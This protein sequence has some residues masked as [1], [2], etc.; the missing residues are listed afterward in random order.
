[1]KTRT[2]DLSILACLFC[3]NGY[4]QYQPA[5]RVVP[6]TKDTTISPISPNETMPN[7]LSKNNPNLK[8]KQKGDNGNGFDIYESELDKMAILVPNKKNSHYM[9]NSIRP[10]NIPNGINLKDIYLDSNSNRKPNYQAPIHI[11]T[12]QFPGFSYKKFSPKVDQKKKR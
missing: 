3:L 6:F 10:Q 11:D 9:P 1:M 4:A 2:T 7:A 8:L 5:I 12:S